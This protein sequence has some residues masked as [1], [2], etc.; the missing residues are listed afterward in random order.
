MTVKKTMFPQAKIVSR[1]FPRKFKT[2]CLDKI[3]KLVKRVINKVTKIIN[4]PI[5]F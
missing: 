4:I 1:N 2:P 3:V 5:E